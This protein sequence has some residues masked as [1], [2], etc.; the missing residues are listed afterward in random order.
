MK[1]LPFGGTQGAV[2]KAFSKPVGNHLL[3]SL[4]I[5]HVVTTLPYHVIGSVPLDFFLVL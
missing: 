2:R 3:R 4:N 1:Q 5:K